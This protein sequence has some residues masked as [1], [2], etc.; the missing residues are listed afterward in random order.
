MSQ[1]DSPTRPIRFF[2][3][4][5]IVSVDGLAP[6]RTALQWLREDARLTGT[7][8][9]CNEGD[10]GAC[11]VIVA[12]LP[13]PGQPGTRTVQ[14]LNLRAMNACLLFLPALDG[15][16]LLSVDELQGLTGGALHPAQQALI[17]C[18]GSQCGFCTPGFVM[19]LVACYEQESAPR[20]GL[21]PA[22]RVPESG[23]ALPSR[24]ELADVLAGNLC[25]CT[26]YRPILDAG[27]RMF[28][29]ARETGPALD[30]GPVRRALE[31]LAAD[32]PL[33]YRGPAPDGSLAM[34]RA[35][36]PRSIDALAQA[37]AERPQARLVG[38][39]TDIALWTNKQLRL[40]PELIFTGACTELQAIEARADGVWIGAAATLEAAWGALTA[41]RPELNEAWRRFASPPVRHAGTLGG[42]VANGSPIGDAAP[43]LMALDAE[44]DLRLG[45]RRRRVPIAEF[46][47]G[48]MQNRLEPGE[49][50]EALWVPDVPGQLRAW[51]ISKRFD[52]DISSVF[53]AFR[54]VLDG[55]VVRDVRLAF[56]GMAATSR[57]ASQ[58]EAAVLGQPWT[59]A[60]VEAARVALAQDF[61]PLSD[62]RASASYR[63]RVASNLLQ[64]LWLETRTVD[65]LPLQSTRVG[66]APA[67]TSE[68][69]P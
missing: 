28:E 49:F 17:E 13:A 24:A 22:G 40:L 19:S 63:L 2:H 11:T 38:G 47:L 5:Q 54:L 56:G 44:L 60:T 39:A 45:S 18:H 42:N 32:P 33:D 66:Y 1:A 34:H 3:R 55:D 58:A 29:L 15:K 64:R 30:L 51:K 8:E 59:Q 65:A 53:A 50:I 35:Q 23:K 52:S 7:K 69:T 31:A 20:S 62:L 4:G 67:Q 43:V 10:C 9:G 37:Y 36:A 61:Q 26:G 25:R 14:G 16:A 48:Y 46:Y 68:A 57:R 27:Q 6:T 12:D 41:R 21:G